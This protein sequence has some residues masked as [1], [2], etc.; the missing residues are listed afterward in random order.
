MH[1]CLMYNEPTR[2]QYMYVDPDEYTLEY[3][4]DWLENHVK[5][6]LRGSPVPEAC[7]ICLYRLRC[8]WAYQYNFDLYPDIA[9]KIYNQS[10]LTR[11]L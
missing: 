4:A 9:E 3:V 5:H 2:P 6:T 8:P 1:G 11:W 7:K 10:M